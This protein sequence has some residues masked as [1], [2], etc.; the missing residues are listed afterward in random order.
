MSTERTGRAEAIR[1]RDLAQGDIASVVAL[2]SAS[3]STPWN[4]ET[5]RKLLERPGAEL[6]ALDDSGEVIGYAVLWCVLDQGELA[7]IAIR[8]DRRGEGL[9]RRLLGATL[10]RAVERGVRTVFLEVRESNLAARTL[11][12][13]VGFEELGRRPDYYREPREDARVLRIELPGD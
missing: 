2:E 5:F 4:E 10:A 3:F 1:V 6:L 7:N 9:G 12:A 11:Y 13:D 8:S